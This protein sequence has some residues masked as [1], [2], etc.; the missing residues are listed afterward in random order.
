MAGVLLAAA[1]LTAAPSARAGRFPR[2]SISPTSRALARERVGGTSNA[3]GAAI[4]IV[5]GRSPSCI[6][7]GVGVANVES[8]PA[9]DAPTCCFRVGS[10]TKMFT[11]AALV[12]LADEGPAEGWTDPDRQ[13]GRPGQPASHRPHAAHR[14]A[15]DG[16]RFAIV[17]ARPD[18][19]PQEFAAGARG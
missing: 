1:V 5:K 3:P 7:R 19:R 17:R 8:G 4:A 16:L 2:R 6:S 12:S 10:V 14:R 9:G 18:P 15:V 13:A 11:T